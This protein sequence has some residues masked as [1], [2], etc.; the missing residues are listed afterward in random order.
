M[1]TLLD[2]RHFIFS[3]HLPNFRTFYE[4]VAAS[5]QDVRNG[6]MDSKAQRVL[7]GF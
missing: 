6:L 7:L 2:I 5:S 3:G 1:T 4:G